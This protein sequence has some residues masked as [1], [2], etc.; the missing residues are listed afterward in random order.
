MEEILGFFRAFEGW[1]YFLFGLSSLF[2]LRRF[3]LAWQELR[4][5]VFGLEREAAQE[6]LNQAAGALVILLSAATTIFVLVTFVA[7]TLPTSAVIPTATLNLLATATTTLAPLGAEPESALTTAVLL[8]QPT[9]I[10]ACLPGQAEITAPQNGQEVNGVVA[11]MGS[12]TIANF[13]FYKFEIKRP[14]ETAWLTIQAGNI[15]VVAGKLGDWDTSRLTP[16]DYQLALVVVDN[17]AQ[18]L[19]PCVIQV[20]VTI[21]P[22]TTRGP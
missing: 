12:A 19:P 5:A 1:F 7:P 8:A 22:E 4:G 9:S 13:G 18:A 10:G 2:F 21:T 3:L 14:D 17:Q 15:P 11:V 20:R 16:G 6:R